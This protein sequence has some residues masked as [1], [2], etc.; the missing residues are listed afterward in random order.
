MDTS[1]DVTRQER[2]FEFNTKPSMCQNYKLHLNYT[3]LVIKSTL[4][5]E[6]FFYCNKILR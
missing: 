5:F 4:L 2:G 3:L 6:V 1:S